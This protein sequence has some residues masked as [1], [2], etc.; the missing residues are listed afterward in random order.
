MIKNHF[1]EGAIRALS[2]NF[3]DKV[4]TP[5]VVVMH[6]TAGW[7]VKGALSTFANPAS[8]VSAQFTIDTDGTIYQ[9][10]A[11]NKRAWHAGPSKFG[12]LTDLNTHSIG[13]EF[14]NPGYLRKVGDNLYQ[15]AVGTRV[16]G[17]A[18]G[19]MVEAKNARVGS[20][21]FYWPAYT[22][23]QIEAGEALT[24]AL[25]A[26]YPITA[27]VSHE[28]IDTRGW[29]T[30]PGPAFPMER[31]SALLAGDRSAPEL[32][33]PAETMVEYIVTA[34][35]LNVRRA[36]SSTA[37]VVGKVTAGAKLR[38]TAVEDVWIKIGDSKWVHGDYARRAA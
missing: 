27:I 13:I 1:Y 29:K 2:P 22:K 7:T 9:H 14:V 8:K 33:K 37:P 31:F 5:S 4:I 36:P 30:D 16:S 38:A 35:V 34:D 21:T 15:D 11:C 18:V 19:P 23:A 10:V 24:R 3:T 25:I 6:Y 17:D 26:S 28:E 32:V 12:Q 20:G